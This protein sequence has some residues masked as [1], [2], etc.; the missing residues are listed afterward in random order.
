MLTFKTNNPS[1]CGI[2]KTDSDGIV[3]DF[4][5]KSSSPP[6]NCANGAIYCFDYELINFL[7]K[8]G[9]DISDFSTQAIPALIGK[10][11]TFHTNEPF[12]DIGTPD[13]LA[14]AQKIWTDKSL[15]K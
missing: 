13:S 10:I 12:V 3:L 8:L 15:K 4:V 11:K 7:E 6:G 1:Q 5:E 2:V 9:P 14:Y